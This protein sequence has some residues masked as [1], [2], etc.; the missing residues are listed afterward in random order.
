MSRVFSLAPSLSYVVVGNCSG[1]IVV[2]VHPGEPAL[3]VKRLER[4]VGSLE[5]HSIEGEPYIQ[6][7]SIIGAYSLVSYSCP[8][9]LRPDLRWK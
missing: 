2:V 9:T 7:I 1:K 4:V 5:L 3:I 8:T 6:R